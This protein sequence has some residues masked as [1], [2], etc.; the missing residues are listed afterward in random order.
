M[1]YGADVRT[2]AA[3]QHAI[4]EKEP[5]RPSSVIL[6]DEKSAVPEATQKMDAI[7]ESRDKARKRLRKKLAGDLDNIILMALRKEP[8]RRYLSAEQFSEDIGRYLNGQPVM[9][10]LDTPGYR[11]AKFVRRNAKST[12]AAAITGAALIAIAALSQRSAHDAI[13]ARARTEQMLVQ[14][15]H[16]LI[17]AY[18]RNSDAGQALAAA[19]VAYAASPG[20]ALVRHD[21]AAAATAAGDE[22]LMKGNRAGATTFYRDALTQYDAVAQ[23]NTRDLE[24]Q[25]DV[26]RA[27][28]KL[29]DIEAEDG[30]VPGA[31]TDYRRALQIAQGLAAAENA[32]ISQETKQEMV[33]VTRRISEI[34]KPA[35]K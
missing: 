16:E 5:L 32:Q 7:D 4:C 21:L 24:A 31:L 8:H 28:H 17:S 3:L 29:G 34:T 27:A 9:A 18:L 20:R 30:N 12:A 26:M 25:R 2:Q 6:T 22:Y 13:A 10:R 19:R 11:L 1:P 35:G 23:M 14:T 15:R 33:E